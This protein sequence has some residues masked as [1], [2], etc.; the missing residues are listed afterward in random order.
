MCAQ[1]RPE[2]D[3]RLG[4]A[5]GLDRRNRGAAALDLF[6]F[7]QGRA[8]HG[9]GE[10]GQQGAVQ[11]EVGHDL[12]E[13]PV[14]GR[15]DETGQEIDGLGARSALAQ[16]GHHLADG[17]VKALHVGARIAGGG[18]VDKGGQAHRALGVLGVLVQ[19]HLDVVADG[20]GQAG[21]GDADQLAAGIW[22][23]RWS[24]RA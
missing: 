21:G 9:L 7:E 8:V 12:G 18:D 23:P 10:I 16:L 15:A 3:G 4:A 19:V 13:Q 5:H 11:A 14:I 6:V 24:G 17:G 1:G 20:L 2:F 22:R